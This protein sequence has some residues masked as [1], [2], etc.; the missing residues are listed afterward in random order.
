M[1]DN[2]DNFEQEQEQEQETKSESESEPEPEPESEEESEE[3]PEEEEESPEKKYRRPVFKEIKEKYPDFFKDFPD[4]REVYF[5]ESKFSTLFPT[6]EDAEEAFNKASS[7]D[8]LASDLISGST[9]LLVEE[10]SK[11]GREHLERVAENFL[12]TLYKKDQNLYFS[13]IS[14][15]IGQFVRNLYE[16]GKRTNNDNLKAAAQIA[17]QFGWGTTEIDKVGLQPKKV[18][19]EIEEE[20]KRLLT[21]KQRIEQERYFEVYNAVAERAQKILITEI[22]KHVPLSDTYKKSA[23]VRDIFEKVNEV[24]TAD[25][26]HIRLMNSLWQKARNNGYSIESRNRLIS[27]L[28]ARAKQ[29]IPGVAREI[30]S[31]AEPESEKVSG[32]KASPLGNIGNPTRTGKV[33][34]SKF[35]S[36]RE[37]LDA[38][39]E[40]KGRVP[41]I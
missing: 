7:F 16:E 31:E 28:I 10:L 13:I 20:K 9:E 26:R 3:E 38:F 17:A 29:I 41:R 34:W 23:A 33:D 15:Y 14:P 36:E 21:E 39:V 37:F 4:M 24:L 40:K 6:I 11:A 27:T 19:P 8:T 22:A 1:P 18:D 25:Q 30:L 2:N 35:K 12:P 32:G 5:R